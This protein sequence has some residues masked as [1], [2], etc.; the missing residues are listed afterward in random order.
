MNFAGFIFAEGVTMTKFLLTTL[1]AAVLTLEGS[2]VAQ[3]PP[4]PN[5]SPRTVTLALTEYN[6][7][8]DLAGRPPQGPLVAPVP[9]VL[10]SADLR[11]R[12]D[13][14]T[15]RGVFNVTGD[16]LRAGINRVTLLS[17]ATLVEANAAGRPVPII[18][19]GNAHMALLPGPNAFALTLE[20]GAPLK[21]APGRASF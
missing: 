9:A 12:A 2:V 20:W 16:V 14:E 17:G 15:A 11:V 3:Q 4:R 21:F 5:E 1:V 7:L 6:R 18:A 19:E 8:I 13:R 10:A